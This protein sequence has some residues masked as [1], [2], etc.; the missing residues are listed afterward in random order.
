MHNS[1]PV[2]SIGTTEMDN[3]AIENIPMFLVPGDYLFDRLFGP[4]GVVQTE[5]TVA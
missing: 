3:V 1:V 5:T 2:L 4:L